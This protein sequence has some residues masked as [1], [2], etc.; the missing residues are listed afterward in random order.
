MEIA[1]RSGMYA[2]LALM[3]FVT[4]NDLGSLGLWQ[5]TGLGG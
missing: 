2:L 4:F 5:V 3:L 1:F